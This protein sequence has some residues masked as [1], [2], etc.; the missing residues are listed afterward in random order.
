MK[1]LSKVIGR[2]M[3]VL[4]LGCF[5]VACGDDDDHPTK[6]AGAGN[7]GTGGTAGKGGTGGTK[8]GTGGKGGAGDGS[9][10]DCADTAKENSGGMASDKCTSCLCGMKPAETT[11]CT[12][13]CWKLAYCVPANG[14]DA[15]DTACI[16]AACTDDLGDVTKLQAAGTLAMKTPFTSCAA[17]CFPTPI[18]PDA[19]TDGGN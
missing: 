17:D 2:G 16:V 12:K 8:A 5:A 4:A 6:D 1:G 3:L 19:E 18:K 14:C 15:T 13:D 10:P 9:A 11:A 7:G